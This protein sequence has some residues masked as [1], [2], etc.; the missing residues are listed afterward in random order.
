M[1]K[2]ET[3]SRGYDLERDYLR[4]NMDRIIGVVTSLVPSVKGIVHV[5]FRCGDV[6]EYH[7]QLAKQVFSYLN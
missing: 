5:C 1:L 4:D 2:I 7:G 3:I 6:R